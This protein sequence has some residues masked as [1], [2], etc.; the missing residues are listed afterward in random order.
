METEPHE[1]TN[2]IAHQEILDVTAAA[3]QNNLD[4]IN[5]K[6]EHPTDAEHP[7]ERNERNVAVLGI[8]AA[9]KSPDLDPKHREGL[10]NALDAWTEPEW[11]PAGFNDFD[12]EIHAI[13]EAEHLPEESDT[14]V[15]ETKVHAYVASPEGVVRGEHGRL[16]PIVDVEDMPVSERVPDAVAPV[17]PEVEAEGG[18]W[19]DLFDNDEV[20][21]RGRST[22]LDSTEVIE[23]VK[24]D[25]DAV[26]PLSKKSAEPVEVP[27]KKPV[28]QEDF[29]GDDRDGTL[30]ADREDDSDR[31]SWFKR[32]RR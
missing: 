5:A 3:V 6:I 30:G 9:L 14:G 1:A 12:P 20:V 28:Y 8:L 23:A 15:S 31:G 19:G 7:V 16:R 27:A 29:W 13:P 17:P 25:A 24:A 11:S 2:R 18:G 21:A 10:M 4:A 32:R 22:S 26:L